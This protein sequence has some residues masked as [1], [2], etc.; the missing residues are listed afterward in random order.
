MPR[1][2]RYGHLAMSIISGWQAMIRGE[3]EFVHWGATSQDVMDTTTVLRCET[4]STN[5]SSGSGR[6][7]GSNGSS[8]PDAR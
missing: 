1:V 2:S 5:C 6:S 4:D 3:G 7:S 8:T